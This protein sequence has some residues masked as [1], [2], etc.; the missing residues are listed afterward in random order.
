MNRSAVAIFSFLFLCACSSTKKDEPTADA[1]GIPPV[2]LDG[3][4]AI[5]D[6][7]NGSAAC[8]PGACNYQAQDCPSGQTCLPTATPPAS[9][10]WPPAC[11]SAGTV[12]VG[13]PCTGWNDC[14]T[15]AFCVGVGQAADGGTRRA[16]VASCA[17]AG[18]GLRAAAGRAASNNFYLVRPSGGAPT[19]ANADLCSPVGTCNVL[20]PNACA[21]EP[22]RS[23]QLV[24]PTGNVACAPEGTA[25]IGAGCSEK[26]TCVKL[27]H[28]RGRQMPAAVQGGAGAT[29]A[30]LPCRR[31]AY[32]CTTSATPKASGNAPTCSDSVTK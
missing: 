23:C 9:G 16:P 29:R 28:L 1:G 7:P 25:A 5:P 32:A 22:G 4:G 18:I 17:A 19:Y 13:Q 8:Q 15:G 21:D 12:A 14:V 31:K 27:R 10:D 3:G 2:I 6:A 11:D 26:V 24:D 30:T 20:D